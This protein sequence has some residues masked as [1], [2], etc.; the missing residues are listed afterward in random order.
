MKL[1]NSIRGETACRKVED[2][3]GW[4][5]TCMSSMMEVLL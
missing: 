4:F 1:G 5:N 2:P 3:T